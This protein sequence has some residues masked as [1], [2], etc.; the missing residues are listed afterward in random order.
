MNPRAKKKARAMSQGIG[1]P[2]AE[3]AAAKVRVLVRTEAPSPRRATAPRGSGWVMIPTM[4]ARKIARSCHALRVTPSGTGR[5]HTITPVAIDAR[6]GLIAAP[7]HGAGDTGA[8]EEEDEE[9]AAAAAVEEA[10][11]S[12]DLLVSGDIAEEK[13][14]SVDRRGF[15][16]RLREE[17]RRGRRRERD[18]SGKASEQEP[19]RAR[20]AIVVSVGGER[21]R[22]S[23][24]RWKKTSEEHK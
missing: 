16:S 3:K 19:E 4:V 18:L 1:S 6:R 7:C 22:E 24:G 21:E 23:K 17:G 12:V 9:A 5:N 10:L 8:G 13:R 15:F 14:D 20:D 11:T 2:K